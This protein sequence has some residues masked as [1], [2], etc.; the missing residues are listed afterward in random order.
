MIPEPSIDARKM[1]YSVIQEISETSLSF[2]KYTEIIDT[3]V[4]DRK[5][6]G[7]DKGSFYYSRDLLERLGINTNKIENIAETGTT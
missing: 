7:V 1:R 3:Y 2:D 6:S 4:Q 5:M